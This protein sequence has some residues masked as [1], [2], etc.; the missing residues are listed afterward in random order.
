MKSVKLGLLVP[1]CLSWRGL[2][3]RAPLWK[4]FCPVPSRLAFPGTHWAQLLMLGVCPAEWSGVLAE[5]PSRL[6]ASCPGHFGWQWDREHGRSSP[7]APRVPV[8]GLV[9]HRP[10]VFAASLSIPSLTVPHCKAFPSAH[11]SKMFVGKGRRETTAPRADRASILG[12][13]LRWER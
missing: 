13:E 5:G 10:R 11:S 9:C 8:L 12:P 2:E 1:V 6:P 4:G 7:Q 3:G